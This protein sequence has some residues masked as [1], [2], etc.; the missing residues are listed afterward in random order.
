ELDKKDAEE[1]ACDGDRTHEE[2]PKDEIIQADEEMCVMH[3]EVSK[4]D[5]E[6]E[7]EHE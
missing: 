6:H 1:V 4:V 7:E 3:K 5:E 2:E